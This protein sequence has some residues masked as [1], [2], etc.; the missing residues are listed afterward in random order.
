MLTANDGA[1]PPHN[2]IAKARGDV[3]MKIAAGAFALWAFAIPVGI[4]MLR[5]SLR[6]I[7]DDIHD[8]A[9]KSSE[10]RLVNEKRLILLE[11]RQEKV[12]RQ[13]AD[14]EGRINILERELGVGVRELVPRQQQQ[15]QRR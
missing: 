13:T 14:H 15:Q 4:E 3:W 7:Q 5:A 9:T 2:G 8:L 1:P 10:Y 6:D 11:E 12:I